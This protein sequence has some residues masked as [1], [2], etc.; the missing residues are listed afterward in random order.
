MTSQQTENT[1]EK[2][3]ETANQSSSSHSFQ[4]TSHEG[5]KPLTDYDSKTVMLRAER[6]DEVKITEVV[7]QLE[8]KGHPPSEFTVLE[9]TNTYFGPELLLEAE[10]TN[11]LLTAPGP[12]TYLVLW[13]ESTE[14][15]DFRTGWTQ[16]AEVKAEIAET[17][18]YEFCTQCG[19]PIRSVQHERLASLGQCPHAT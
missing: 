8:S 15:R 19:N 5:V 9:R 4:F 11:Y 6:K 12:N 17:P 1:H 13:K 2:G 10:E 7:R 14:D 18:Q 3:E 16:I